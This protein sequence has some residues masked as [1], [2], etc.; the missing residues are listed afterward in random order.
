MSAKKTAT[1]RVAQD[2]TASENSQEIY[3]HTAVGTYKDH[4]TGVWYTVTISFDPDSGNT[5]LFTRKS[6]NAQDRSTAVEAFKLTCVHAGGV[7]CYQD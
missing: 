7:A 6:T 3:S 4:K 2:E 1:A 5:G